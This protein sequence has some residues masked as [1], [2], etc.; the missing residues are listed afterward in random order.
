MLLLDRRAGDLRREYLATSPPSVVRA[1]CDV[2]AEPRS[3]LDGLLALLDAMPTAAVAGTTVVVADGL[4]ERGLHETGRVARLHPDV[5]VFAP[6]SGGTGTT[7][8]IFDLLHPFQRTLLVDGKVP[9]DTWTRVARHWHECYRLSHPPAPREP[10]DA[11][12]EALGPAGRVH[13]PGQHP[14]DPQ[15]HDRG[16]DPW[17]ALG[18][19]PRGRA[20]QLH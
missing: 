12:Q 7:G 10:Q 1:L 5:P 13:P 3:W 15:H 4:G 6:S 9:E 20:R 16:R 19:G 14:G 18:A 11:D 8:A 17:P 2:R